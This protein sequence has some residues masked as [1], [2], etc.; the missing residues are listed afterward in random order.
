M[1]RR[2]PQECCQN[3]VFWDQWKPPNQERGLCRFN[4]P[5]AVYDPVQAKERFSTLWPRTFHT[6]WCGAFQL[7]RQPR[8]AAQTF[9]RERRQMQEF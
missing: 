3:C 6:A 2:D 5:V 7:H 4:P 9:D 8:P 1:S